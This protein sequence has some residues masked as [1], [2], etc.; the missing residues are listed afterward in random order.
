MLKEMAENA[1][2]NGLSQ[3]NSLTMSERMNEFET[4]THTIGEEKNENTTTN[5][6]YNHCATST[7]H[8]QTQLN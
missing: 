2:Y 8:T 6:Q 1:F 3:I 7:T 4:N 5:K